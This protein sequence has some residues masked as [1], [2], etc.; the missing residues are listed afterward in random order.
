MM[1]L[2]RQPNPENEPTAQKED[3]LIDTEFQTEVEAEE[4]EDGP[5][6][7]FDKSQWF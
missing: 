6:S 4:E 3:K 1:T 2:D 5:L 7:S